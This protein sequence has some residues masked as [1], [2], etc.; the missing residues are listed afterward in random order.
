MRY[1]KLPHTFFDEISVTYI[2]RLIVG[3]FANLEINKINIINDQTCK[4]TY[5]H[6]YLDITSYRFVVMEGFCPRFMIKLR[7]RIAGNKYDLQHYRYVFL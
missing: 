6:K 3:S 7:L 1:T 5:R 4:T 2:H